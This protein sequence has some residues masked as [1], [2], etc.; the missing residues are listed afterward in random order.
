[1]LKHIQFSPL[2]S[3]FQWK[4]F[5]PFTLLT[6]LITIIFLSLYITDEI[7]ERELY[8]REQVHLQ[9]LHLG[10]SIRLTLYA[11]N[12]TALQKLAEM[13]AR[14]PE[15]R[16]VEIFAKDGRMLANFRLPGLRPE[17]DL[18]QDTVEV[19]SDPLIS[20]GL[21]LGESQNPKGAL[22]GTIRMERGTGDLANSICRMALVSSGIAV[23]FWMACILLGY[24][25]LQRVTRSF[26]ALLQGIQA[27]HDGDLTTR[28][29]IESDDESGMAA[30]AINNLALA[31][32]Q[33]NQENS[34]LQEERLEIE[35]QMYQAQK[36]ESLG[37]MAGGVAHDFNNLLHAILG[38]MEIASLELDPGSKPHELIAN[39]I[40]SSKHAAHLSSL[41]LTYV[42]KGLVS[43][44]SL[45]LNEL[46]R[47]S[48][49]MIK[50]V[51]ASTVSMELCLPDK[52]P[53]I[54]AGESQILQVVMNLITNAVESIEEH[55]GLVRITTGIQNCDTAALDASLLDVKPQPGSFVF[56][57]VKDNG[58]GMTK[59]TI[60]RLFD[61]FFTTKFT[62]RG[63]GMSAVLGI[64][65][66]H[67]GALFVESEPGK[68]TTFRV[69]FPASESGLL[70]TA[71]ESTILPPEIPTLP[72]SHLSGLALVVDDEKAVL[73]VCAK[74]VKLCGFTVITA[75]NGID[76][77]SKFS[78]HA[79][80]I[81]VVLMD[82]S[83]PNMDGIAAMNQI[84][85]IRPDARVIL[86][87]GFSKD[88]LSKRIADQPPA[89]FI[90]K[91]YTMSNL[92]TELRR[93]LQAGWKDSSRQVR[94]GGAVH[95]ECD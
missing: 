39:A 86:S 63:L 77:V 37:L 38:N 19:R 65:R 78:K 8:L 45:D 62:G 5:A 76:A 2:R 87:S 11:E 28:I 67:G 66:S 47:D 55:P 18:I 1:M 46:V 30:R 90:V 74:M 31:L 23:C 84:Y 68:G 92:E 14:A 27:L 81:A 26:K 6:A 85:S 70:A 13:A 32:Q 73:R 53:A 44:K 51:A 56:F 72:E 60:N 54:M 24:L 17:T 80:E 88:E 71:T 29:E 22:I 95:E 49:D 3:S 41:M 93:V 33:R 42:G 36:L 61:P 9:A 58:C 15:M 25:V 52:L 79:D 75:H 7:R 34:R 40:N 59:E 12:R 4:L 57:E 82:L 69:L 50:T 89:G 10:E 94:N 48:F 43:K 16:A 21:A 64:V 35:R 91:P 20:N 83:M